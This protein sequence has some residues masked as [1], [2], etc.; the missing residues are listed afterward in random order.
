M[1]K[2]EWDASFSV[3]NVEIDNQHKEWINI[4]NKMHDSLT[5]ADSAAYQKAATEVIQAMLEYSR[6]HFSFE[7]EYMR[8]IGYPDFVEHYRLHKDFDTL[9]YTYNRDIQEGRVVLN[10]QVLKVIENWLLDHI[11]VEDK[12]YA[13]HLDSMAK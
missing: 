10:S 8:K 2:I 6:K 1:S 13:E 3:N 11:L 7:E 12:K 5:T 4:Y 9:I